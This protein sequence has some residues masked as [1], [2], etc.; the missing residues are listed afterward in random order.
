MRR[1]GAQ[2]DLLP[3]CLHGRAI[4]DAI[5][6]G[7]ETTGTEDIVGLLEAEAV[8][9]TG[10]ILGGGAVVRAVHPGNGGVVQ[11]RSN[12]TFIF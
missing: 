10:M 7:K 12:F 4:D 8:V 3:S 2:L 9:D 11:V 6:A 5:E 1:S